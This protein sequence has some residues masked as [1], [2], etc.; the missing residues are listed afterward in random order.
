MRDWESYKESVNGSPYYNDEFKEAILISK[1]NE[2]HK[3]EKVRYNIFN[4][5]MELKKGE[6][7]FCFT[8]DTV[9]YYRIK[10]DQTLFEVIPIKFKS[11]PFS[12]AQ[13]ISLGKYSLFTIHE[14][15]FTPSEKP[16]AYQDAKPPQY[17]RQS[18][19][20]YIKTPKGDFVKMKNF[21][22]LGELFPDKIAELEKYIKS[23]KLKFKKIEDLKTLMV[24]INNELI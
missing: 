23:E 24:Y 18:P 5:Q 21:K 6:Q 16:K 19:K 13:V 11:S 1:G 8:K 20:Y 2:E 14:V 15:T 17:N 3:G 4:D 12:Y 9:Q 22:Q 10:L 7:Y